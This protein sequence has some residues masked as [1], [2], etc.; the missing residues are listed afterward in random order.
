MIELAAGLLLA[1]ILS[2]FIFQTENM[3]IKK[4]EG[5]WTGV[6]LMLHTFGAGVLAGILSIQWNMQAVW[7]GGVT[8]FSHYVIDG[9]K[10]HWEYRYKF[11]STKVFLVDQLAHM[12]VIS[13]LVIWVATPDMLDQLIEPIN[14]KSSLVGL[15]GYIFLLKPASVLIQQLFSQWKVEQPDD[16]E[17]L[18]NAGT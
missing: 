12:L 6:S 1:H 18:P 11:G 17:H 14:L 9:T 10:I 4:R 15:T 5:G 8:A 3:V 13:V 2:D 7:I 16:K